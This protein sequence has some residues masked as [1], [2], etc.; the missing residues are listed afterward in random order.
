MSGR[1][2]FCLPTYKYVPKNLSRWDSIGPQKRA[3]WV[4]E[5]A[6]LMRKWGMMAKRTMGM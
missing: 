2:A 3:A 4:T 5:L 1:F 6:K